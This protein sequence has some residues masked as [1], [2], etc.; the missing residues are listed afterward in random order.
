[1]GNWRKIITETS[2]GFYNMA[3]DEAIMIAHREGKV[4][5]TLRFYTWQP[6]ALSLGYFQKLQEEIDIEKC[7]EMGVDIVRRLTGGRAILHDREL[8]YSININESL[9]ILSGSVVESYKQVSR[10]LV[11]GLQKLNI[12]AELKPLEKNKKA[13]QGKSSACFDA[14][15][16]YEVVVE[17]KKLIGSAQTRKKGTILQHGSIPFSYNSQQIFQLFNFSSEKR[18]EKMRRFYSLKATAINQC[19]EKEISIQELAEA[20]TEGLAKNLDIKFEKTDG[21]TSYEQ[22]LA[23]ELKEDK[24]SSTEW[25]YKK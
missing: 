3:V 12:A 15:S 5:P 22:K 7:E 16:W 25:N 13:P 14:P 19:C 2:D 1:M 9:D 8:T 20:L 10:G 17:G 4:P 24:Y 23:Q 11:S 6:P 21:L 18:R